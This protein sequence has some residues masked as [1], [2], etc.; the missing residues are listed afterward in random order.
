ML[1]GF[2][3]FQF[4][5][6]NMGVAFL[7]VSFM[8]FYKSVLSIPNCHCLNSDMFGLNSFNGF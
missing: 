5:S 2:F 3:W 1:S 6:D 7:T 4:S 8:V